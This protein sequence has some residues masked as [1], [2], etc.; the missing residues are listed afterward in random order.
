[1]ELVTDGAVQTLVFQPDPEGTGGVVRDVPV[2][3]KATLRFVMRSGAMATLPV[4]GFSSAP[5]VESETTLLF[6]PDFSAWPAMVTAAGA[7]PVSPAPPADL[8]SVQ[9][10]HI[11]TASFYAPLKEGQVS[12]EDD[13]PFVEEINK[14]T[15]TGNVE[16]MEELFGSSQPFQVTWSFRAINLITGAI[17]PVR[18]GMP[19]A[20]TEVQVQLLQGR[21]P[22]GSIQVTFPAQPASNIY[23]LEAIA[24]IT[25]TNG[26][27]GRV[28]HHLWSHVLAGEAESLVKGL[29]PAV[30]ELAGVSANDLVTASTIDNPSPPDDTDS[31]SRVARMVGGQDNHAM[32]RMR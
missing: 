30:A 3:N 8:L 28:R 26:V 18:V 9:K 10:W 23:E 11:D 19:A 32:L 27:I 17:V 7:V 12:P 22:N 6:E 25:D 13:S 14:A 4:N 2:S 1:V 15:L 31:T 5:E 24:K 20:P 29:L 21:V 16:R